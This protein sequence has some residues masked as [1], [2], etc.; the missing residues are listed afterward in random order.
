MKGGNMWRIIF[1]LFI[2]VI[3]HTATFNELYKRICAK[4]PK[5][6]YFI[7]IGTV[8]NTGSPDDVTHAK[9]LAMGDLAN[10]I[11]CKVKSEIISEVKATTRSQDEYIASKCKLLSDIKLEGVNFELN[12]TKKYIYAW[13]ILDKTKALRIYQTKLVNLRDELKKSMSRIESLISKGESGEALG[14]LFEL[15]NLFDKYE[16]NALICIILGGK[17]TPAPFSRAKIN[18][19]MYRLTHEE[20]KN[21]EDVVNGI[22][23]MI[24]EQIKSYIKTTPEI[25][26]FPFD[27]EDTDWSSEFSEYLRKKLEANLV[28][29]IECKFEKQSPET[30]GI[31]IYGSY[32]LKNGEIHLIGT[33]YDEMKKVTFGSF[34]AKFPKK[35]L[36]EIGIAYKPANFVAAFSDKKYFTPNEVIYG[37]LRIEFWTNKGNRHLLFKQGEQMKLY[38]RTNLPC[39]IQFIYH[40]ANGMRT[41]LVNNYYI[42]ESKI[43]KVVELPY[44][45]VCAP[46]FGVE[47]L[48]IFASTEPLPEPET[49]EVTIDGVKYKVLR[50]DLPKFLANTRGFIKKQ[51]HK[52]AE[53]VITITTIPAKK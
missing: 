32:W 49:K 50:D 41:V 28:K 29:F 17:P 43:N 18:D 52:S 37:D 15:K 45:F 31:Y 33:L 3:I 42:D 51:T 7:G 48:Q 35:F 22:S 24:S 36:Q 21:F 39:Y 27:Y 14:E 26:V 30:K 4:Y 44:E 5:E 10:Q 9:N 23:Y 11:Q 16:E 13:A 19:L 38:V 34:E 25:T 6:Y 1:F 47:K 8:E 53:R 12:S 20:Y 46:P 40:L 2:P